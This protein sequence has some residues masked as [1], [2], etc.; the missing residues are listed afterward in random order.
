MECVGFRGGNAAGG[1]RRT[2][3]G[4]ESTKMEYILPQEEDELSA[5]GGDP[6]EPSPV[7]F[8]LTR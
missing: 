8:Y 7:A 4:Y 1:D 6:S 5:T 2:A 3:G